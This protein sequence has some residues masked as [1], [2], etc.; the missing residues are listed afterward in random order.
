M[1]LIVRAVWSLHYNGS[2]AEEV[3]KPF[4]PHT[5]LTHPKLM[6]FRETKEICNAGTMNHVDSHDV[7]ID[8]DSK[9]A[10]LVDCAK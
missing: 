9:V 3:L 1:V 10:A 8:S 4:N 6:R 5:T 7:V 2:R